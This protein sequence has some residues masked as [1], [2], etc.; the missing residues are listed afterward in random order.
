M[1]KQLF[2]TL[3]A[4]ALF[5]LLFLGNAAYAKP[6]APD[7]RTV[8]PLVSTQWLADHLNQPNLVVVD[9][10]S[11]EEYAAGHIPGAV[12]I[13]YSVPFSAWMSFPNGILMEVPAEADLYNL[14]G[15]NGIQ[16]DSTVV[17]VN[18]IFN[19]AVPPAYPRAD[20]TRAALTL[21]YGGVKNT[22]I[23]N[24]GFTKWVNES[25]ALT[26]DVVAPAPV[27]YDGK[28]NPAMIATK[29]YVLKH[30]GKSTILD[31]RDPDVYF[32]VTMEPFAPRPG[33]IP[34]AKSLPAPWIWNDDGT[35]KSQEVLGAMASSV[36]GK[37]TPKEV[38]IYCGVGGYGSAWWFVLT[39]VLGYENVKLYDGSAQEWTADPNAPMV[40]Y[41][42]E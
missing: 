21:L 5:S 16:K 40:V 6:A 39:Q 25:R 20:A 42:W 19:P 18:V 8:E 1:R 2:F 10:R 7:G 9:I 11:A 35:Y 29:D 27:T 14:L 31:A 34:T 22:A 17:V 36:M 33:H 41:K 28:I 13:P 3:L 26:T 37:R 38:I 24:G 30:I 15:S 32:G 12:N 23:L 4:A